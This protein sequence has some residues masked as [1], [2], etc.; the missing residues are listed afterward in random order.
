MV[1][2]K[3]LFVTWLLCL[4]LFGCPLIKSCIVTPGAQLCKDVW[5]NELRVH[6]RSEGLRLLVHGPG[7]PLVLKIRSF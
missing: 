4:A 6:R 3:P 7:T 1:R 5:I 2:T